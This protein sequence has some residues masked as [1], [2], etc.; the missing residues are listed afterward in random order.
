[1]TDPLKLLL[2]TIRVEEFRSP[3]RPFIERCGGSRKTSSSSLTRV[4]IIHF[5][6]GTR[7]VVRAMRVEKVVLVIYYR[8]LAFRGV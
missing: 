2:Q 8:D 5:I 1:M 7:A 6:A 3:Q 4:A